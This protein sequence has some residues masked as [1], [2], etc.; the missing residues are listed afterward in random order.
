MPGPHRL[1]T[2]E[3]RQDQRRDRVDP[4]AAECGVQHEPDKHHAGSQAHSS[5]WR[6]ATTGRDPSVSPSRFFAR[7]STGITTTDTVATTIPIGDD[8]VSPSAI[9]RRRSSRG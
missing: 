9:T 1:V 8:V 4:P 6:D 7:A 3:A 5:V 2:G